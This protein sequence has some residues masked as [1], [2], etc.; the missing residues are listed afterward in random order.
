MLSGEPFIVDIVKYVNIMDEYR[1]ICRK[2]VLSLFER[3]SRLEQLVGLVA[4]DSSKL[5]P[6]SCFTESST[7]R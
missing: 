4:E 3:A 2:H 7:I 1:G 5:A 6:S